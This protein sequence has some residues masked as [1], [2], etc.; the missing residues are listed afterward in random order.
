M[1]SKSTVKGNVGVRGW[2]VKKVEV[3]VAPLNGGL[4]N[5]IEKFFAKR[6]ML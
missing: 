5:V 4:G 3:K 2:Q 6:E 1:N